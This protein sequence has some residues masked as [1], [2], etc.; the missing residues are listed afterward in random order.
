MWPAKRGGRNY[1][2]LNFVKN[3]N[4]FKSTEKNLHKYFET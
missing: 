4:N 2:L 3:N 1:I